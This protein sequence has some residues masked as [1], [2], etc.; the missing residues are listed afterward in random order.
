MRSML[1]LAALPILAAEPPGDA[2]ALFEKAVERHYAL[3]QYEVEVSVSTVSGDRLSPSARV[4]MAVDEQ[5]RS[6][7][8]EWLTGGPSEAV[9]DGDR[10]WVRSRRGVS[11]HPADAPEVRTWRRAIE[12]HGGRF[13][14]L[15]RAG[16]EQEWVKWEA[17]KRGK[18]RIHC[19]VIRVRPPDPVY[20]NW[21]ETLWV[22]AE[23]GL[24]WRSVRIDR[25]APGA[26]GAAGPGTVQ[27]GAA[28]N[29]PMGWDVVRT[30]E[31]NWLR[32]EG[33]LPA[34]T[35]AKPAWASRA[36]SR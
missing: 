5:A 24:V 27:G 16:L 11:D 36:K 34:D 28:R 2:R 1:A 10:T 6:F 23:T 12:A 14:L 9:S 30:E 32:T 31:Y 18:R 3:Q 25:S 33:E 26:G 4:R 13:A 20:G 19:G 8:I 21:T 22:E 29:V 35:F 7:R 17:V 15:G